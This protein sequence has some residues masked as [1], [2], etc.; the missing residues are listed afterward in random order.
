MRK[1]QMTELTD[2]VKLADRLDVLKRAADQFLHNLAMLTGDWDQKTIDLDEMY[3]SLKTGEIQVSKTQQDPVT[4]LFK[5]YPV[6]KPRTEQVE[7]L[8]TALAEIPED[9]IQRLAKAC[10]ERR[11]KRVD[12]LQ[13]QDEL[14]S[15]TERDERPEYAN[16]SEY[17][18]EHWH[19]NLKNVENSIDKIQ[20]Q[21]STDPTNAG[22][23]KLLDK[24]CKRKGVIMKKIDEILEAGG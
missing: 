3:N 18:K 7:I 1:F 4:G 11:E 9:E 17:A 14:Q 15:D 12:F 22:L 16:A 24:Q 20:T 19:Q 5:E 6:Y 8:E 23:L 21:L 13:N 2:A 10:S